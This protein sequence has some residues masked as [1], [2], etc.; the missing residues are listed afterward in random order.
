M[1]ELLA[2]LPRCRLTATGVIVG[3]SSSKILTV[4]RFPTIAFTGFD[5]RTRNVSSDSLI[6]S[7]MIETVIGCV[8]TAGE[9]VRLPDA[10]TKSTPL[11][12]DT[13]LVLQSTDIV[14][15]V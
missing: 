9:K 5:N 15:P 7:P 6:V 10:A 8:V 3:R 14:F 11:V 13:A 1:V 12:A 2:E 4:A